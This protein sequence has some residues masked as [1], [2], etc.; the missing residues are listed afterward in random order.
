MRCIEAGPA[1]QSDLCGILLRFRKKKI[2]VTSD[3]E[4]MFL[5]ISLREQDRYM[6][7]DLDLEAAPKVYR[8]TI[9]TFGVIASPFLAICTTCEGVRSRTLCKN[10]IV[11]TTRREYSRWRTQ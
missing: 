11:A 7:R 3:I 8:M 5:Q 6:W 9:V 2:A 10:N 1:L 4:K